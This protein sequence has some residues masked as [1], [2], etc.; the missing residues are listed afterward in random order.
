MT[1][2]CRRQDSRQHSYRFDQL[3]PSFR[4]DSRD[5]TC[6][7]VWAN[8]AV[9]HQV[10]MALLPLNFSPPFFWCCSCSCMQLIVASKSQLPLSHEQPSARPSD[11]Q[12]GIHPNGNSCTAAEHHQLTCRSSVVK[13]AILSKSSIF[14]CSPVSRFLITNICMKQAGRQVQQYSTAQWFEPSPLPAP[15]SSQQS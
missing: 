13:F 8:L 3:V 2:I 4:T 7:K 5:T 12:H 1:C 11:W 9:P 10:F 15:T 14:I 6:T